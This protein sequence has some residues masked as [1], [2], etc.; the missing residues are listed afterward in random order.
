MDNLNFRVVITTNEKSVS[1]EPPGIV[2]GHIIN[3]FWNRLAHAA[4][5]LRQIFCYDLLRI[6]DSEIKLDMMQTHQLK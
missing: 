2:E 6:Y 5:F 3:L 1:T 4:N